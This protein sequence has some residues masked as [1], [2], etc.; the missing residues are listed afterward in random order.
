MDFKGEGRSMGEN[1]KA[2]KG[3]GNQENERKG[4][5]TVGLFHNC[6]IC[7]PCEAV[8]KS[9]GLETLGFRIYFHGAYPNKK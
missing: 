6:P 1:S 3:R 7:R 8:N 9:K 4:A 2:V 5:H